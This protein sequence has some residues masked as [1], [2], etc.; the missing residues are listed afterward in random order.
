MILIE[1]T[2]K[3]PEIFRVLSPLL[4]LALSLDNTSAGASDRAL[5]GRLSRVLCSR[6]T[7][8][9]IALSKSSSAGGPVLGK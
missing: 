7:G 6:R 8:T 1:I 3:R 2:V 9:Y 4:F 5:C